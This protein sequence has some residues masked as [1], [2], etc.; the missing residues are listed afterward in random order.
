[1]FT[2]ESQAGILSK[3]ESEYNN[4]VKVCAKKKLTNLTYDQVGIKPKS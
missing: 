1:M 3:I 2:G 4:Q